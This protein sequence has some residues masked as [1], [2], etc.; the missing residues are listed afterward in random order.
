MENMNIDVRYIE[1]DQIDDD[2]SN[3]RFKDEE[4]R[5]FNTE[6]NSLRDS[7]AASEARYVMLPVYESEIAG[8]YKLFR[9]GSTRLAI[10]KSLSLDC[11]VSGVENPY[12]TVQCRIYPKVSEHKR[13]L[14][15]VGENVTRG[16]LCYGER[17]NAMDNVLR[18]FTIVRDGEDWEIEEFLEYVKA[19]GMGGLVPNRREYFYLK[20]C[21][22]DFITPGLLRKRIIEGRA[23]RKWVIDVLRERSK[24]IERYKSAPGN[25]DNEPG[26]EDRAIQLFSNV[27]RTHDSVDLIIADLQLALDGVEIEGV[28]EPNEYANRFDRKYCINSEGD[29]C[30]QLNGD[31][32]HNALILVGE[33]VRDGGMKKSKLKTRRMNEMNV[34][35]GEV[36]GFVDLVNMLPRG[37]KRLALKEIFG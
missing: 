8:R 14:L 31:P 5:V 19:E 4:G 33:I 32:A 13:L 30:K 35:T 34:R 24:F 20:Q 17:A 9:G 16:Q 2:H 23:D 11:A 3:V 27:C 7:I 21:A 36:S 37:A 1:I 22:S 28:A 10:I 15:S 18:A 25:D 12:A 6:Y 29:V 26:S